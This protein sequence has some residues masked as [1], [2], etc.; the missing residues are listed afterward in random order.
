MPDRRVNLT[1]RIVDAAKPAT[2][3]YQI[4]DAK[5]R[6]FGVRVYPSGVKTF[7]LQYR[8][9]GGR[10]R[11]IALG[12]Y[13]I[14]TVEKARENAIKLLGAIVDGGTRPMIRGK[15]AMRRRSGNSPTCTLAKA[16][17]KSPT[18]NYRAGKPIAPTLTGT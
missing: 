11:K 3:D 13:G 2:K 16:P 14:V 8:N 7:V 12:R 1:K 6:G 10:T 17:S 4:W 18:R 9:S 5:V 15:I